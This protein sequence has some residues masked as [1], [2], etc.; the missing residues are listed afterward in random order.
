MKLLH[1]IKAGL[2]ILICLVL[3]VW[4][5]P[6]WLIALPIIVDYYYLHRIKWGKGRESTNPIVRF[7]ATWLGDLAFVV[8]LVTMLQ[9][10]LFQNFGIPSSSLEKTML[11]GDYL[12]VEKLSY[13]PRMPMTPVALPLVHNTFL[14]SKS[15][16]ETP[17]CSYKRLKGLGKVKRND[18]VVFNFPAGDTVALQKPNPDYYTLCKMHTREAVHQDKAQF[19]DIVYRPVDRRDHYVKRCIGMPG[20]EIEIRSNQVYINGKALENPSKLQLNYLV[21]TKGQTLSKELL[22]A[23]EINYRDVVEMPVSLGNLADQAQV[24]VLIQSLAQETGL[25]PID[26]SMNMGRIYHIPLTAEMKRTL[27]AEPY[28]HRIVVEQAPSG[29]LCY[30]LDLNTGWSRD[31]YGPLLIPQA[32][33]KIELTPKNIALYERCI[34]AY[35]GHQLEVTPEGKA[36]I[37]GIAQTHYTFGMDYYFMLGDNRHNSA[38]SRYWGFVPEDHIVGKPLFIFFSRNDEQGFLSGIRWSRMFRRINAD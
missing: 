16:L 15:Y 20:E 38:D 34:R 13:G 11:I 12:V 24:Q 5:S 7:V 36:L 3:V 28:I 30:P 21:Q 9:T 4:A 26:S 22:D 32:G 27:E 33:M 37:D 14:G 19:G 18:I 17:T 35:E 1:H 29:D 8:V 2:I 31:N 25:S 6:W 10:F 23:L